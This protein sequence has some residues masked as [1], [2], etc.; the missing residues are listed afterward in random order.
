MRDRP[1]SEVMSEALRADSV[2]AAELLTHVLRDGS[3]EELVILLQQLT[4]ASGVNDH[5][6]QDGVDES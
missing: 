2:Y 1:H 4:L 3:P 6:Q 5:T